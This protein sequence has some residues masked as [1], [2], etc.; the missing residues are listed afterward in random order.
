MIWGDT[1]LYG[2]TFSSVWLCVPFSGLVL[3]CSTN[4]MPGSFMYGGFMSGNVMSDYLQPVPA[5]NQ[6]YYKTISHGDVLVIATRR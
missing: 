4:F 3:V 2:D 6:I 1:Q 5:S